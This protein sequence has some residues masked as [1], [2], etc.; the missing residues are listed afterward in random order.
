MPVTGGLGDWERQYNRFVR[1]DQWEWHTH[2][3]LALPQQGKDVL[4]RCPWNE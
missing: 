1:E 4:H 3:M 2:G